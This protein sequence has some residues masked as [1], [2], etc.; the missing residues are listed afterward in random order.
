MRR[1][2]G[3]LIVILLVFP[4]FVSALLAIGISTWALDRDFYAG[5]IDD[6]RLF[7]LPDGVSSASWQW[8][9]DSAL[10]GIFPPEAASSLGEIFTP[11][12]MRAE[13][14]ANID[15]VFDFLDGRASSLSLW[16]DL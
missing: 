15:R 1:L 4:L 6:P 11:E 5:L 13:A 16:L 3:V 7:Q 12:Y 2:P 10:G 14:K 8:V 9:E